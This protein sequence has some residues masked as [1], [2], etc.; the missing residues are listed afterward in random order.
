M[1]VLISQ[2]VLEKAKKLRDDD[3]DKLLEMLERM[4]IHGCPGIDSDIIKIKDLLL[5][6]EEPV[7][8]PFFP[9]QDIYYEYSEFK[10]KLFH[11]E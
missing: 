11:V 5:D 9:S 3:L 1:Q 8:Y 10:E 6:P 7:P 2:V 4:E